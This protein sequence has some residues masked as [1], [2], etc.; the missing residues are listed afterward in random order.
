M[1]RT[2]APGRRQ[3]GATLLVGMVMLAMLG[4][5]G[6]VSYAVAS[7]EDRMVGNTREGMRA[8]EAAETALRD[9]EAQL[10]GVGS[11]PNFNGSGGMYEAAAV[12]AM[13]R[14]QSI[15]WNNA[16]L[17]RVLGS[18][19]PDVGRQPRCI[20]ER[21]GVI[22]EAPIDGAISGPQALVEQTVFRV[23]SMGFGRNVAARVQL[24]STF[25][26]Q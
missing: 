7:M 26:R 20:V 23:T 12:D 24:Q 25:R 10:G 9:C 8:F 16:G 13:P 3:R 15:D 19:L 1:K 14:W 5:I 2:V 4:L 17:V 6:V 22:D 11:L 18:A 21:I